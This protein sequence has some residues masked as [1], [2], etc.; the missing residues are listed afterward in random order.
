M[1]ELIQHLTEQ[2]FQQEALDA[3]VPVLVDFW[4]PWCAPCLSVAPILEEL[5]KKN[6]GKLKVCK[7]NVDVEQ[8]LAMR[9]AVR[10][11]PS[12]IVFKGGQKHAM[13]IGT[14]SLTQLQALVDTAL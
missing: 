4:A 9:Y 11:I 13:E 8:G 1:S 7:V 5:A 3:T 14:R 12:L 10:S 6:Q 2:N